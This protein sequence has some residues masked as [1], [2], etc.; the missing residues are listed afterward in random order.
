MKTSHIALLFAAVIALCS[1][2]GKKKSYDET[3]LSGLTTRTENLKT[4]I[5]A[6]ASKGTIVGQLNGTLEGIGWQ[7]DSDRSD[8]QTICGDRP[9]AVGYELAGIENAKK[10]NAEGLAFDAIRKDVLKNFRRGALVT[11]TWTAPDYKGS[12][13]M[14]KQY[15]KSVAT[16]INSLHDEYEIKAPVVLFLYPLNGTSWYC[17]L[18][19]DDYKALYTKTQDLLEDEG[20]NN[21][22]YGYSESY[23]SAN[24]LERYPDN[25]IDVVNVSILQKK[26]AANLDEYKRL[27]NESTTR[28]LPFAQE[29]NCAYG[30]ITGMEGL[31]ATGIFSEAVLP[32][33]KNHRLSYIMFGANHG[34]FKDCHF[35]T[36]YPGEGNE[37]IQEFMQLYNDETTV[38]M[39]SLNGLYLAH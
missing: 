32:L 29:H 7:C 12:D 34:D 20:V 36:P 18:T 26:E 1:C 3:A 15:A 25:D 10:Q 39:K 4:N 17:K 21:V 24:F 14:L 33:I 6:Y 16:F 5:K 38:F 27:I 2:G 31:S 13:D 19:A 28:A 11:L 30:M 23:P 9:A 8:I 22:V 35:Y 37:H